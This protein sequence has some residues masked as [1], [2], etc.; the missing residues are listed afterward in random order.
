MI[1]KSAAYLLM[2]L[3]TCNPSP[4]LAELFTPPRPIVGRYELCTAADPIAALAPPG[5]T[6]DAV[7]PLDAFGNAGSYDRFALVRVY[8]ATR[9]QVARRWL[10]H[11]A[12]FESQTFI[13][14][15]PDATLTRLVPGTMIITL[16]IT[17]GH[18]AGARP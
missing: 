14:P 10:M 2:T 16:R 15:Y 9:P 17:R 12:E 1:L 8:G 11:G 3:L 18:Q 13:S 6:I 5:T 7:E 4:A